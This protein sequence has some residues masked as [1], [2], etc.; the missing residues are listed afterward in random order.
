M[1]RG[2]TYF[3]QECPTCGRSLQVRV[4]YLG[5]R[6]ACQHCSAK[7]KAFHSKAPEL[8]PVEE[9]ASLLDRAEQL[10]QTAESSGI[11]VS[12]RSQP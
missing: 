7:F 9:P 2:I 10:L 11:G 3:V 8:G 1:G 12:S 4:E 5:R 6:V